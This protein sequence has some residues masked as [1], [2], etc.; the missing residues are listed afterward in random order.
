MTK[1]IYV[2][3]IKKCFL[4]PCNNILITSFPPHRET[5]KKCFLPPCNNIFITSFLPHHEN[6]AARL[7]FLMKLTC[8]TNTILAD[9]LSITNTRNNNK[10]N[11]F[12]ISVLGH[13]LSCYSSSKFGW[14]DA[15]SEQDQHNE[16]FRFLWLMVGFT[17]GNKMSVAN[18]K[19]ISSGI[20]WS[21]CSSFKMRSM[22]SWTTWPSC[23]VYTH[24]YYNML[25]SVQSVKNMTGLPGYD[26]QVLSLCQSFFP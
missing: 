15:N 25:I 4:P 2:E 17:S 3:T 10:I 7:H 1:S 12:T 18:P 20:L 26:Q 21:T 6:L 19:A 22:W 16:Q 5:F 11:Y 13:K 8:Y 23:I 24:T 14:R 9:S